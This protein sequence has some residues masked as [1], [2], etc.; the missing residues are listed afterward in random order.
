MQR[1][2]LMS[3]LAF[4]APVYGQHGSTPA[5]I[6]PSP[7]GAKLFRAQC[8]GCHGVDGSGT[9][10]GPALNKGVFRHGSSDDA[11]VRT[12]SK[13]VP[14]TTMP[15]FSYDASQ[16]WQ[17]VTHIRSLNIAR[18]AAQVTGDAKAGAAIFES[19]C[20]GCHGG[21]GSMTGPDLTAIGTR[22]PEAELRRALV[23]PSAS[24]ASTYWSVELKTS[25]GQAVRGTRL[26]EDT[27][28]IQ[29]RDPQGRLRSV[30]KRD[31]ADI[32]LLRDS[33]M[34]SFAGKLTDKQMSDLI[35]F[36]VRGQL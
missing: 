20:A 16:M 5:S 15:G 12:I 34:P 28:S 10:Q 4:W 35:A 36:L 18:S 17:L 24:V 21:A 32:K 1:W 8:A 26:N 30:L 25:G 33:T 11:V 2:L 19:Q 27:S 6:Q 31:I 13:G 7:A 3:W 29:L 23:E 14:G 22:M 9:G